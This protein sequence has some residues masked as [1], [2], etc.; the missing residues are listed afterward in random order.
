V[1]IVGLSE[2]AYVRAT[3]RCLDWRHDLQRTSTN[4]GPRHGWCSLQFQEQP[5]HETVS[6]WPNAPSQRRPPGRIVS[7]KEMM[8]P[9]PLW[10]AAAVAFGVTVAACSGGPKSPGVPTA[11]SH[12]TTTAG[13]ARGSGLSTQAPLAQAEVYSQ[14]MRSHGVPNFPDP[15]LTPAGGYG[16]RTTGIDP[17]SAAFQR[18]LQACK[19]LPSPWQPTGP[20]LTPGQQQ[21]WL[22]WAKCVRAHGLPNFPDP[23]FSGRAVQISSAGGSRSPQLQSAMDACKSEMPSIGGLGG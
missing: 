13:Q 6:K 23:T 20:Q 8:R 22:S 3:S 17:N 10:A 4:S 11:G 2:T 7:D 19:A 12:T 21:A 18:A 15:V 1:R 14:C 16:Y 9:V 5:P